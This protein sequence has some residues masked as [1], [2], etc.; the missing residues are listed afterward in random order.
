[1]ILTLELDPAETITLA[2]AL[3]TVRHLLERDLPDAPKSRAAALNELDIMETIS[4]KLL[5][6][7]KQIPKEMLEPL[8]LPPLNS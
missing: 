3:M 4:G 7:A 2:T 1:M 6:L 5:D 8:H